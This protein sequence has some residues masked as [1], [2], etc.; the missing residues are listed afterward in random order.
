MSAL[1]RFRAF[2]KDRSASASVEYVVLFLPLIAL[3]FTSFQIALAFHF[4]LTAQK[5]V[6][7]GARVAAV[8]D[9][10]Y[11]REYLPTTNVPAAGARTGDACALN[12]NCV[13]P[14]GGPWVCTNA[15]LNQP[16]CD[17]NAFKEVFDEVAAVAY[18][19]NP[20]NL[21]VAYDYYE[22]GFANGPFV[23]LVTVTIAERPFMLQFFFNLAYGQ[24]REAGSQEVG[25]LPAVQATAIAEDLSSVN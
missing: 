17:A 4:A 21:V 8:R 20:D 7:N 16:Q 19:L 10:V 6:E 18:L 14:S 24:D 3:V 9:P 23:P 15:D 22:L 12:N 5:A 13:A 11:R 1:G 2:L 25:L